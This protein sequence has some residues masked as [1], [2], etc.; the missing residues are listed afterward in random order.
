MHVRVRPAAA[1]LKCMAHRPLAI[2]GS[3][4][5]LS[6]LAFDLLRSSLEDHLPE[7]SCICSRGILD[8]LLQEP[9][10]AWF[11]LGLLAGSLGGPLLDILWLVRQRWRR[12]VYS[13]VFG[14]SAI[15]K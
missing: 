12:C 4:G 6:S 2:G 9:R 10:A 5:A 1:G 13:W 8:L 15:S 14:A 3:A 11:F 7:E